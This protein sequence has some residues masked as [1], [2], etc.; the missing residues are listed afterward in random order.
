MTGLLLVQSHGPPV[1]PVPR[2]RGPPRPAAPRSHGGC[3]ASLI[4]AGQ[5]EPVTASNTV[6]GIGQSHVLRARHVE[7]EIIIL[8]R[9]VLR[10]ICIRDE[11]QD[12]LKLRANIP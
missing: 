11:C 4:L 2:P 8:T 7:F 5:N 12:M 9:D 6:T 1:Q 10:G 3:C